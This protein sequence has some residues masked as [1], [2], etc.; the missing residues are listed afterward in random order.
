DLKL[1]AGGES[2]VNDID[3]AILRISPKDQADINLYFDKKTGLPLKAE[4]RL[5]EPNGGME[6]NF[7]FYFSDFK[8]VDG[9]KFFGKFKFVREGKDLAE[10]ELSDFKVDQKFE[11]ATFEKP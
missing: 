1:A 8:D 3:A 5:K 4:T 7:E 9:V 6:A 10:V 2:K 11:A